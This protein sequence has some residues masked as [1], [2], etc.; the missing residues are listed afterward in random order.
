MQPETMHM[1]ADLSASFLLSLAF[2]ASAAATVVLFTVW[3][4]L[5]RARRSLPGVIGE[6]EQR[7]TMVAHATN[8]RTD[9]IVRRQ[10]AAAS[11]VAG[12]RAGTGHL[13][14]GTGRLRR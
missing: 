13:L 3:L 8:T 2:L 12:L 14:S 11:A 7:A 4:G 9:A 10:I 5:R 6:L 1:L